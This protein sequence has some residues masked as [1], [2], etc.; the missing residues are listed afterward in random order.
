MTEHY[1]KAEEIARGSAT[2]VDVAANLFY[3][4]MNQI[5]AQL[6]L[7][8][9]RGASGPPADRLARVR[10]S[11]A[12]APPDFWSVVGQ[13]EMRMYECV[14]AG[15]LAGDLDGLTKEFRNHHARV[16]SPS[17][18]GSVYDTAMLVLWGYRR[19]ATSSEARAA[20]EMLTA[21]ATLAGQPVVEVAEAAAPRARKPARASRSKKPARSRKRSGLA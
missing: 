15:T 3:P 1:A 11:M 4:M 10:Q 16:D 13:T 17:R 19:R 14:V 18:W 8:G 5:F 9:A 7:R 12:A 6:A 2:D 21:L 20:T